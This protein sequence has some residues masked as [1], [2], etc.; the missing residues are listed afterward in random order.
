MRKPLQ[1]TPLR[2]QVERCSC[3]AAV[4]ADRPPNS[5][6]ELRPWVRKGGQRRRQHSAWTGGHTTAIPDK[7]GSRGDPF[8][9]EKPLYTITAK[10]RILR[11]PAE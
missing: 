6:S 10:R 3:A 11:R 1:R 4:G 8:S 5:S 9:A 7:T 2:S